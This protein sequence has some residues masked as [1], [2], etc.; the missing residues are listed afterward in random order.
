MLV[1]CDVIKPLIKPVTISNNSLDMIDKHRL[2]IIDVVYLINF[3]FEFH[4]FS[5]DFTKIYL[6]GIFIIFF[7]L[8]LEFFFTYDVAIIL[9]CALDH[10]V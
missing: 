9:H 1:N 5:L 8:H 10:F 4:D 6:F 3:N 7:F 2:L